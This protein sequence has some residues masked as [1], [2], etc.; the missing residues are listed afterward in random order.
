[1]GN[2]ELV[3]KCIEILTVISLPVSVVYI[4]SVWHNIHYKNKK[5]E[6]LKERNTILRDKNN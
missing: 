1:M 3:A 6:L 4:A 2:Q 5:N